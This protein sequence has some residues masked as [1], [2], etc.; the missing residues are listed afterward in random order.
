MSELN[1]LELE[2]QAID[3]EMANNQFSQ[4]ETAAQPSLNE[5][6]KTSIMQFLGFAVGLVNARIPFTSQHFTSQNLEVIAD[7]L[8]KVA[9]VE[10]VDLNALLGDP[11]S[12]FGAWMALAI[13]VGLPS[14]TLYLAVVE[15]NKTKEKQPAEKEVKAADFEAKPQTEHSGFHA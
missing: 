10:G 7:S 3:A 1:Q 13:A 14:F 9:D 15:Y 2:A 5:N 11:N 12:R 8:I 6:F 4:Q